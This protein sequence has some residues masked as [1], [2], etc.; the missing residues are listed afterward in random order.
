MTISGKVGSTTIV[1]DEG[2]VITFSSVVPS[3]GSISKTT[4]ISP[5]EVVGSE[6][7]YV[8][9]VPSASFLPTGSG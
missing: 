4:G 3:I 2:P 9:T 1:G 8:T 6:I 5:I 7:G